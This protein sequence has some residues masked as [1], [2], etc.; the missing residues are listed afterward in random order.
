MC[1]WVFHILISSV[2]DTKMLFCLEMSLTLTC[3]ER[4]VWNSSLN[5]ISLLHLDFYRVVRLVVVVGLVLLL[6]QTQDWRDHSLLLI[7]LRPRWMLRKWIRMFF[8][9]W[10]Y[11]PSFWVAVFLSL[12]MNTIWE[13]ESCSCIWKTD[14]LDAQMKS[15]KLTQQ[16]LKTNLNYIKWG[17][18]VQHLSHSCCDLILHC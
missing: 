13:R 7:G 11:F 2:D 10:F 4:E 17:A 16:D 6:K 8:L 5:T 12:S 15:I 14:T 1:L 9:F 3:P 18:S